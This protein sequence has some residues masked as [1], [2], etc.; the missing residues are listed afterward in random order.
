MA[1]RRL[2]AIA[3]ALGLVAWL[4]SSGVTAQADTP[5]GPDLTYYSLLATYSWSNQDTCYANSGTAD[6]TIAGKCTITQ[7]TPTGKRNIAVCVQSSNAPIADQQ[8]D[9]T[10]SNDT[11]NNYALVI[12]RINQQGAEPSCTLATPC[13]TQRAS[14]KQTNPFSSSNFAGVFQ[15]INQSIGQR[16]DDPTQANS[17]SVQTPTGGTPGPGLD[18]SSGTGSNFAAVGESSQQTQFGGMTQ[19]QDA[20]Q[21]VGLSESGQGINQTTAAPGAS[22]AVLGQF[23]KQDLQSQAALGHQMQNAMQDGDITQTGGAAGKN[24][25]SGNQFQ[26]QREQGTST[27]HQNQFGDPK[28]CSRQ[29]T[30]EFDIH[31]ET[32]QFVSNNTAATAALRDQTEDIVGNCDS[33]FPPPPG[34][35]TGGCTVVQKATLNGTPTPG[36][37]CN[38]KAACHQVITCSSGG[39]GGGAGSCTAAGVGRAP[40][41]LRLGAPT[42]A[43]S[44]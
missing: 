36:V 27:T 42:A 15:T 40:V 3:G 1:R 25:A 13:A 32:V 39:E 19:E 34:S 5:P 31:Q 38:G 30:G 41:T 21:F 29:A 35:T 7:T 23:Q 33:P 26:V 24:F 9:I 28:C 17:Q 20:T 2:T 8:C 16:E 10:Q 14:I 18:Q 22:A 44:A 12:Q 4:V 11:H 37:P 43:R 6:H